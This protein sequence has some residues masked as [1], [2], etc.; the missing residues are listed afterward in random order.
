VGERY[1]A[2]AIP[3]TVVID[4]EGKVAYHHTGVSSVSKLK[5][6]IEDLL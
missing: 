1:G 2:D 4:Q 6:V 5:E 3:T